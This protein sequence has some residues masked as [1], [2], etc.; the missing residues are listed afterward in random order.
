[1]A[2]FEMEKLQKRLALE[3]KLGEFRLEKGAFRP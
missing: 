3:N 1:M 2:C